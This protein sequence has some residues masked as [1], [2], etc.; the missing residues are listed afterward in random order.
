MARFVR[1]VGGAEAR[2]GRN[3]ASGAPHT[4][5]K[6]VPAATGEAQRPHAGP[7]PGAVS[8]RPQCGQNG[9][10]ALTLALQN[11]QATSP[12]R[13]VGAGV[14]TSRV[15]GTADAR[16]GGATAAAAFAPP[17]LSRD[18]PQSMQNWA[19]ASLSRPQ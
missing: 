19:P 17:D 16:A 7:E 10:A 9:S 14:A 11:G 8:R 4:A 1:V 3:C 6:R 18:L 5:Q 15:P 2:K 12:F 13:G